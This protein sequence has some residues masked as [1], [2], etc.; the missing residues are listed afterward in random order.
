MQAWRA[1]MQ[2]VVVWLGAAPRGVLG[3]FREANSSRRVGYSPS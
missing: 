1:A 2:V 3:W